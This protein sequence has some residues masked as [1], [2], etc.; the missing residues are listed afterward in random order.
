MTKV[1]AM[2]MNSRY[3]R[4]HPPPP[5]TAASQTAGWGRSAWYGPQSAGGCNRAHWTRSCL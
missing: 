2:K 3:Y 4:L 1:R 5:T